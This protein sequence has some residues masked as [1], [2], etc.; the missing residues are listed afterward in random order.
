M[1]M[2]PQT[3]EEI[4]SLVGSQQQTTNFREPICAEVRLSF[5]IR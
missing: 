3:F 2:T 1:R 4:L 5:T